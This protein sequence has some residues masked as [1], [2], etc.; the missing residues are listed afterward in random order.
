M[1]ERCSLCHCSL[2]EPRKPLLFIPWSSGPISKLETEVNKVMYLKPKCIQEGL[3]ED[4]SV[5]SSTLKKGAA[6]VQE[7]VSCVHMEGTGI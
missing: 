4:E 5:T 3:S 6:P 2:G 7:R 1:Q